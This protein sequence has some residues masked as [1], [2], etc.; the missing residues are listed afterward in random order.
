MDFFSA[1]VSKLFIT[2][3]NTIFLVINQHKIVNIIEEI[4]NNI[5]K[6]KN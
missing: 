2:D 1:I 6:Y 3:K 5:K 4:V